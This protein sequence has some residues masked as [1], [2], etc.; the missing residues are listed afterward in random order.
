MYTFEI[1]IEN[2]TGCKQKDLAEKFE[3]A[4]TTLYRNGQVIGDHWITLLDKTFVRANVEMYEKT[5]HAK[6]FCNEYFLQVNTELEQLAGAKLQFRFIGKSLDYGSMCRCRSRDFFVLQTSYIATY[7]PIFCGACEC[8]VPLYRIPHFSTP[9]F[10]PEDKDYSI[11][12]SWMRQY[13]AC[14]RLNMACDFGEKWGTRQMSDPESGLSKMGR[15]I[16]AEIE[17]ITGVPTYYYLYN[18]RCITKEKDRSRPCP[19]CGESWFQGGE[20]REFEQFR[21]DSCRLVSNLTFN[22]TKQ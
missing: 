15:K 21:C 6:K 16:C 5:S 18:Y 8:V 11:V 10:Y 17:K 13:Q 7:S 14:D 3:W 12:R 20:K 19:V 4:I 1:S 9:P 2:K 22:S